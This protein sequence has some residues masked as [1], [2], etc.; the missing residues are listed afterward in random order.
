MVFVA[1][2][3]RHCPDRRQTLA[4][5]YVQSV[6]GV[7]AADAVYVFAPR[8]SAW[9]SRAG[10][11]AD[12]E[13]IRRALHDTDRL[14]GYSNVDLSPGHGR[15][16]SAVVGPAEPAASVGARRPEFSDELRTAA[17]LAV[18]WALAWR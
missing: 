3:R 16:D 13:G 17:V 10:A 4:P 1:V 7:D 14:H 18:P 9:S 6:L 8:P 2:A 11:A 12:G 15:A 5:R